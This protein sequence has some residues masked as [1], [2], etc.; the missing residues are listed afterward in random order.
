MGNVEAIAEI[1]GNAN[2]IAG[3]TA[4]GATMLGPGRMKHAGSG[5]TIIGELS[6]IKTS[7]LEAIAN[8]F[9]QA[10][11]ETEISDN[12]FG[13]L[14]DKLL[15]NVGI[16]A[17]TA[18]TG[19]QNGRL[20]EIPELKEIL[21]IAVS[22]GWEV[23]KTKGIKLNF[24]DPVAHTKAVCIATAENRSSMLQDV[25]N[26]RKTEIQMINGAILKEGQNLGIKTPV[27]MVLV[28]LIKNI[29]NL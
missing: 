7:R 6:G 8:V 3:T 13:L 16:N 15:V 18:I 10:G 5:K 21:E 26:H 1:L 17:L 2:I 9:N 24:E 12:V 27:N 11:L 23:A 29:E 22:E 28:N 20:V 4:H 25:L 14:W 19:L